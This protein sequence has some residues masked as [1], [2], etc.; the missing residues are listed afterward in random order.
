[1]QSMARCWRGCKC[2]GR[3]KRAELWTC[4]MAV[5]SLIGPSS[6]HT[7][8]I[9]LVDGL[10]R[11]EQGVLWTNAGRCGST[12]KQQEGIDRMCGEGSGLG[13]EACESAPCREGKDSH[14]E[15]TN[16]GD[17]RK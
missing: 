10:R 9:G 13:G 4:T 17:G 3:A 6:I 12:H 5:A 16:N 7:D 11:G 2:R 15:R 8:N 1:M 14:D